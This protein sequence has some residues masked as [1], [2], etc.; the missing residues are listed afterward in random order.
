MLSKYAEEK[1]LR[2]V[3]PERTDI[4][5][6]ERRLFQICLVACFLAGYNI[7]EQSWFFL[8]NVGSGVY[9]FI[10][11]QL[12]YLESGFLSV[13]YLTVANLARLEISVHCQVSVRSQFL[14]RP[15]S[16]CWITVSHTIRPPIEELIAPTGIEPTPFQNLASQVAGL[17]VHAT[18]CHYTHHLQQRTGANIDWNITHTFS[19][20]RSKTRKSRKPWKCR[21][22]FS[23]FFS[24]DFSM[25]T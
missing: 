21:K 14:V 12:L 13:A 7:I 5:S 17:L 23:D 10:Y 25:L 4:P 20:T 15:F 19:V 6:Q 22:F 8:L 24:S 18:T 1:Y 3:G 11:F 9:L 16:Q 2:N